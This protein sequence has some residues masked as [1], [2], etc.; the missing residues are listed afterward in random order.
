MAAFSSA[1]AG[2]LASALM[3][4]A[5]TNL[6]GV[7]LR[8]DDVEVEFVAKEGFAAAGDRAGVVVLDTRIDDELRD[9]GFLR[10]LQNRIQTIRKEMA[11]QYTDR[12]RL[13]IRGTEHAE[14]IVEE[15]QEALAAEVLAVEIST[16]AAPAAVHVRAVDLEG[17]TVHLGLARVGT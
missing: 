2:A 14:R 7:D 5:V 3:A 17:E 13:W 15:Y 9:R 8:R 12:I 11:L 16:S 6:L 1:E 10:E 4:G